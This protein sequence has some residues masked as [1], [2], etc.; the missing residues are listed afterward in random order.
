MLD[1]WERN[2]LER[3]GEGATEAGGINLGAC[4]QRKREAVSPGGPE[5]TTVFGAE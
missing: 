5:G 1:M 2:R 3:E 4:T